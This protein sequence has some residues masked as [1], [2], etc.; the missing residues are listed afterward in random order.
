MFNTFKYIISVD[1][2]KQN[3]YTAI[4][5]IERIDYDYHLVKLLR[6]RHS[7]H[8]RLISELNGLLADPRTKDGQIA[9]ILDSTGVGLAVADFVRGAG[10]KCFDLTIHGGYAT[11]LDGWH[12]SAAKNDMVFSLQ[13]VV[14]KGRLRVNPELK[15]WKETKA[16][17]ET[18]SPKVN[19]STGNISYEA[20]RSRD[21]DD[22]VMS[23]AMA[24]LFGERLYPA[25][26]PIDNGI[27]ISFGESPGYVSP[28]REVW[29]TD[30]AGNRYK[31][32]VI[33]DD[34]IDEMSVIRRDSGYEAALGGS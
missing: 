22:L 25:V 17:L 13:N 18:F 16:E 19:E 8:E 3:D 32:T 7:S 11:K 24:A 4:S 30:R 21:H 33:N 6:W 20:I 31:Q 34:Y 12:I 28:F 23:L 15:F 26:E 29:V 9:V 1:I 5:V 27:E 2:G 14:E 10:I